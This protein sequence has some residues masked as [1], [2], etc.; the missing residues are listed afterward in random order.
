MGQDIPDTIGIKPDSSVVYKWKD[1]DGKLVVSS[2]P[3][4][5]GTEYEKVEYSHDTNVIPA[6]EPGEEKKK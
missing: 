1:R 5:D 6:L 3:P 2:T 4:D